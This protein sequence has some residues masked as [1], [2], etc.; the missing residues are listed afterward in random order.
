[1]N[2]YVDSDSATPLSLATASCRS[3]SF[4]RIGPQMSTDVPLS[5]AIDATDASRLR[6]CAAI[7]VATDAPDPK[8]P[9]KRVTS[10]TTCTGRPTSVAMPSTDTAVA[11][12]AL[13]IAAFSFWIIAVPRFA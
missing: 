9:A 13:T 1:M 11:T 10:S 3:A 5:Q 2:H 12:I 8:P 6:R 4:P 7:A